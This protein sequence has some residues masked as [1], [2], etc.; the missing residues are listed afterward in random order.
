MT[1]NINTILAAHEENWT[2][3]QAAD[4]QAKTCGSM[5]GRYIKEPFAD[6][7]AIYRI[8][9]E[10]KKSVRIEVV[11]GLGDDWVIPYWGKQAIIAKAYAQQ[12]LDQRD[13][14]ATLA[15]KKAE[16]G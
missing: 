11:K 8:A 3:L 2:K 1:D 16:N 7:Y 5:V 10:N 13:F 9:K 14:W 15:S 4:K 12:K 6:G